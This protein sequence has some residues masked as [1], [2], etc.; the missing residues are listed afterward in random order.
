MSAGMQLES[1]QIYWGTSDYSIP[2]KLALELEKTG[3]VGLRAG[4]HLLVNPKRFALALFGNQ[5]EQPNDHRFASQ[6]QREVDVEM[7][8]LFAQETGIEIQPAPVDSTEVDVIN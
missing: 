1:P 3:Y 8:N 2:Q 5:G 4:L 6:I 7:V